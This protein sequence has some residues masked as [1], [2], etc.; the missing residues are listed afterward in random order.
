M[1]FGGSA[2]AMIQSIRNNAKQ[3]AN[4]KNY[5]EKDVSSKYGTS[6]KVVDYKKMSP[7]QFVAFKQKLKENELRRQKNLV[8][9][10]GSIMLVILAI[11]IY[12]LFYH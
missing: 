4:R 9:V 5:F 3:L 10:F 11:I 7:A 8:F 1:G 6:T 12:F 2:A